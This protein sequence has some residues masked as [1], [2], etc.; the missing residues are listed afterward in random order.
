MTGVMMA[1]WWLHD[2]FMQGAELGAGVR[3]QWRGN[4]TIS[5]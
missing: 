4:P 1:L 3:R 2:G 5:A